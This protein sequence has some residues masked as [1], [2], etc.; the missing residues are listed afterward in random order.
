M[1]VPDP[2]RERDNLRG[3]FSP[4]AQ[5]A[6]F[7]RIDRQV[8]F[9]CPAPCGNERAVNVHVLCPRSYQFDIIRKELRQRLDYIW[10]VV[11]EKEKQDW[12][13]H[14]AVRNTTS[15]CEASRTLKLRFYPHNSLCVSAAAQPG[16]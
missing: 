3:G 16:R 7:G 10:E 15:H 1:G 2:S 8:P 4:N 11:Y 5:V 12:A 6:A 13:Y 14:G 9:L